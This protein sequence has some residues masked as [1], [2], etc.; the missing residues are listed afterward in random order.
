MFITDLSDLSFMVVQGYT[1]LSVKT[2]RMDEIRRI[3]DSL[4]TEYE[5]LAP[6]AADALESAVYK[7]DF[8]LEYLPHITFSGL[9]KNGMAL[10]DA[11][12]DEL[13][14]VFVKGKKLHCSVHKEK[15]CDHKIFAA[16]HH[17]FA[18]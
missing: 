3:F 8:L 10:F 7:L 6:F 12:S 5:A 16:F 15:P 17:K 14:R 1:N 18:C 11:K 4:D 2:D 9:G 13:V